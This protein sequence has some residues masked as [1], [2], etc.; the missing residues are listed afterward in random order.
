MSDK[1]PISAKTLALLGLSEQ[2]TSEEISAELR[3]RT[4]AYFE[5][6]ARERR[7]RFMRAMLCI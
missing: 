2:M 5:K 1:H 6:T 7:E 3:R 4:N